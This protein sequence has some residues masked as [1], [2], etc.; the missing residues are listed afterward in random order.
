MQT[1]YE[2]HQ[3]MKAAEM[4]GLYQILQPATIKALQQSYD[5]CQAGAWETGQQQA[6]SL[7]ETTPSYSY[8]CMLMDKGNAAPIDT[9][10]ID[11]RNQPSEMVG[12][13]LAGFYDTIGDIHEALQR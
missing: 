10:L 8:L 3:I 12:A 5:D 2:K 11:I 6:V 7:M 1:D 13:I 4:Q 9:A